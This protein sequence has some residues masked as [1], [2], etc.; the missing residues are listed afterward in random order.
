M[1]RGCCITTAVSNAA[2]IARG[3][4]RLGISLERTKFIV[5]GEP[6]TH[7]KREAIKAV[8]ATGIP[9]YAYGGSVN[10]VASR[11]VCKIMMGFRLQLV[12]K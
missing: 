4:R 10:K 8:G 12:F 6:F 2:R 3:A 5:S 9:R 11:V 1:Q 7:S